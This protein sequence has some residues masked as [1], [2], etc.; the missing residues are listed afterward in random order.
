MPGRIIQYLEKEMEKQIK[1]EHFQ[2][3]LTILNE[4]DT[5]YDKSGP[6][7]LTVIKE[8][9]YMQCCVRAKPAPPFITRKTHDIQDN[10]RGMLLIIIILSN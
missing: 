4:K 1:T 3:N 9:F 2:T 7:L 10:F 5:K 8:H 6:D